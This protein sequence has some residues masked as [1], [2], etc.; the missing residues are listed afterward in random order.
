MNTQTSGSQ[1]V[2]DRAVRKAFWRLLPLVFVCYVIAYVDRV[3][4]SFAQLTMGKDLPAFTKAVFSNAGVFFWGYFLLEIPG[5]LLVEKWSARKWITRIMITWGIVAAAT[6]MVKTPMQFYVLRFLLGLAEAGFFPGVVV[7]LT[8]W[9]PA[10]TRA[11]AVAMFIIATPTAQI[12]GQPIS[13][14]ILEM[15]GLGLHG[16]QWLYIVWGLPAVILGFVVFFFMTDRPRQANW[17]TPEERE[18]L[19]AE[20]ERERAATKKKRRMTILE[21]LSHPKVLLLCL[22][23]F[24]GVMANYG[25]EFFLPSI[26]KAWYKI[27]IKQIKW[28][29]V[30]PPMLALAAQL[31]MGWNSDRTKERRF[32]TLVPMLVAGV[33]LLI[34][35]QSQGNLALTIVLFMIIAAGIKAYQPSFWALPSQLLTETAAAASI[36]FINSIGNLGGY[37]GPKILGGVKDYTFGLQILG[38]GMIVSS[39]IVFFLGLGHRVTTAAQEA[40]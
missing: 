27:D 34:V 9:F 40:A 30:L 22:L 39:I 25:L 7:Y 12:I 36:G 24:L 20:L 38:G 35:G 26:I 14:T 33:T 5:S 3:N 18:T 29:V 13:G 23:Y 19:E 11:K 17:L 28:L 16:W 1:T 32:H 31:F 10:K 37:L 8:H 6:A 4:V 15:N 21:G 2:L